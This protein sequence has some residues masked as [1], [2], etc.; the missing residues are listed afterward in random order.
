MQT[1]IL[2]PFYLLLFVPSSNST[3]I[4]FPWCDCMVSPFRLFVSVMKRSN[5]AFKVKMFFPKAKAMLVS[6]MASHHVTTYGVTSLA[7]CCYIFYF[8]TMVFFTNRPK[9]ELSWAELR[10]YSNSIVIVII[11][12]LSVL[13]YKDECLHIREWVNLLPIR[14]APLRSTPIWYIIW[15]RKCIGV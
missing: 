13:I 3:K 6:W 10:R 8:C 5:K 15:I 12:P 9:F 2:T 1:K 7:T 14:P 4:V 11:N